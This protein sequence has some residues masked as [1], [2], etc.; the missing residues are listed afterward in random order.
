[1]PGKALLI[2]RD[3]HLRAN[4][5]GFFGWDKVSLIGV[6]PVMKSKGGRRKL[7]GKMLNTYG[8]GFFF[9]FV[10]L[11]LIPTVLSE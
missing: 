6:L 2:E 7:K 9:F 10:G 5:V 8:K 11:P 1:M 4:D 3:D